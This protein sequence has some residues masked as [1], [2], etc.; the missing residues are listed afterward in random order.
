MPNYEMY[1]DLSRAPKRYVKVLEEGSV[2]P[3]G[4]TKIAEFDHPVDLFTDTDSDGTDG[5]GA[6]VN[7][8]LYHHVQQALYFVKSGKTPIEQGF[9]PDNI[10][11]MQLVVIE[12]GE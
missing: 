1:L 8:V 2:A 12:L 5:L 4:Y 9:F 3:V 11:N 10:T 7:H 6:P